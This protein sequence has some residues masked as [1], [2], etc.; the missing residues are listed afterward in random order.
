[1]LMSDRRYSSSNFYR[2]GFNGKEN[3]SE[4]K[5]EGNQQ[6]YGF[7]I[8]DP[9]IGRFLSVGPL[10]K[11]YPWNSPYS[12]AENDVIRCID[13]DG[14]EKYVV[15]TN[16]DR[17]GR[18]TRVVIGGISEKQ[19]KQAVNMNLKT[20]T[21]KP[22]TTKDVYE[23]HQNRRGRVISDKSRQGGL[24][25]AETGIVNNNAVRDQNGEASFDKTYGI[26][27]AGD[28]ELG[29]AF[30]LRR[31]SAASTVAGTSFDTHEYFDATRN[32]NQPGAA[33]GSTRFGGVDFATGTYNVTSNGVSSQS[34]GI[35]TAFVTNYETENINGYVQSFLSSNNLNVGFVDGI[36]ITLGN[37]KL[38]SSWEAVRQNLSKTFNCNVNIVVDPNVIKVDPGSQPNPTYAEFS[39]RVSGVQN[40]N[41]TYADPGAIR[42][43]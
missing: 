16:H 40:G 14:L 39:V 36:T 2:Y 21:G 19:T 12:Y 25:S 9:R 41:A 38:K 4:I 33:T 7:R 11:D 30:Q 34:T 6:D 35:N 26:S 10:T 22:I 3:D 13:L 8:Y 42:K 23:I 5:G 27:G 17:F 1:M 18:T 20:A 15:T 37:D 28:E 32:F 29:R 24:T 31:G 43:K